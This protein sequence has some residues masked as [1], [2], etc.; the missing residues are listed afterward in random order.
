MQIGGWT[1]FSEYVVNFSKKWQFIVEFVD[2]LQ[3]LFASFTNAVSFFIVIVTLKLTS[4]NGIMVCFEMYLLDVSAF[5]GTNWQTKSFAEKIL[6]KLNCISKYS[7]LCLLQFCNQITNKKALETICRCKKLY[8]SFSLKMQV[9]KL[10]VYICK[11]T[12][13]VNFKSMML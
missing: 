13:L 7:H 6:A 12:V 3:F 4:V 8:L 2:W 10:A 5:L 1:Q 11:A 9:W